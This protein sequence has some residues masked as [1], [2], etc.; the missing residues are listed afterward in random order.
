MESS[1]IF[2]SN[3]VPEQLP[4]LRRLNPT[5]QLLCLSTVVGDLNGVD[6]WLASKPVLVESRP[7]VSGQYLW[8]KNGQ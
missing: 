6:K 5:P 1:T 7:V 3:G 8:T 2:Q 4:F